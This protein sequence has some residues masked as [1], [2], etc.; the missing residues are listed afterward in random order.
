MRHRRRLAASA[1]FALGL[2]LLGA[3]A[4]AKTCDIV[5]HGAI[6]DDALLD[7][8]AIAAAIAACGGKGGTVH[9]P[10][11][12]FLTGGVRLVSNMTLHL[13]GGA[14]L[15]GAPD[16]AAYT[17]FETG[18]EEGA[19]GVVL[20]QNVRGVVISGSGTLD[21][22]GGRFRTDLS[23]RPD[24]TL[25]LM[26]CSNVRV[27]DVHLVD[28]SKYHV[29]MNDCDDVVHDGVTIRA[30][31]LSPNSDGIQIRDSADVRIANCLIETGDDA[32]VLKSRRRMVER[33]TIT[34]CNLVSDDAAIKFGTGSAPGIRHVNVSNVTITGSRYGVALFM[35]DGGVYEHNRF[36]D[37]VIATGGRHA[38]EYPIFVDIDT[39]QPDD[40]RGWGRIR[41][42]S[43][44]GIDVVTRG[45][46]LI[47]GQPGH[48]IEDLSLSNIHV[49]VVDRVDV[50]AV[51]GKPRGNKAHA[52]RT[53]AA[54]HSALNGH[55]VIG[56]AD[57][58][59][60]SNVR[61]V[62]ATPADARP[63]LVTR[64]VKGLAGDVRASGETLR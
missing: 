37:L 63:L 4:L 8:R 61:A 22:N 51:H 6:P 41:G 52:P 5:D 47:Q 28:P 3:P 20:G 53:G 12:V 38:R 45:N 55:I 33:V 1:A 59:A 35:Q 58:V 32:I 23:R 60:L 42:L 46:L 15:R 9:V 27:R 39:R 40:P 24:F 10:A 14:V 11:G 18:D 30:D 19:R 43:F 62:A 21:G 29:R 49:R 31:M 25:G 17:R 56:H 57:G 64:D 36:S 34:N 13:G 26:G 50:T 44:D 16:L 48:D 7:D 54:D 2:A